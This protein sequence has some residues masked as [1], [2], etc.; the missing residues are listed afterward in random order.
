MARFTS[1]RLLLAASLAIL[2]AVFIGYL[3][4]VRKHCAPYATNTDAAGYVHSARLLTEGRLAFT[5]PALGSIAPPDWQSTW[6]QPFGFVADASGRMVPTY[7]VGY[8]LHLAV[9]AW[10][11]GIDWAVVLANVAISGA[12]AL[13]MAALCREFH[14][15]WVWCC[16]GAALLWASPVVVY[17]ELWAMSDVASTAWCIASVLGALRA[18]RQ[19]CWSIAAGLAAGIAVLVRPTN[20]LLLPA[21]AAAVG[22]R[23]RNWL[24]VIGGAAP[25]AAF[26]AWYNLALYGSAFA[27]GYSGNRWAFQGKFVL[28]TLGHFALGLPLLL[29]PVVILAGL[30]V[31]RRTWEIPRTRLVLS[32]WILPF[33]GFYSCYYFSS[34]SWWFVRFLMPVFPALILGAL[35]TA[36]HWCR[37]SAPTH[38]LRRIVVVTAFATALLWDVVAVHRMHAVNMKRSE[39]VYVQAA[40]WLRDHAPADSLVVAR[41]ASGTLAFYTSLP[42]IRYDLAG[43]DAMH[44]L[45][46]TA[47]ASS[48][49]VF[50]VLCDPEKDEAFDHF[51]PGRWDLRSRH[52]FFGVWQ[53][54]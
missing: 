10:F 26:L 18:R 21:L 36:E 33:V 13:L 50:V 1:S 41:Q 12:T 20:V 15:P 49:P 14:L 32:A 11:V 31:W 23:W 51:L 6:Q 34:L 48:R 46:A 7:P 3:W 19:W 25:P 53:R 44:R 40:E 5:A 22:L 43:P 28:P 47:H 37:D 2:L 45:L 35:L 30:G 39:I 4:F 54:L 24:G 8:P 9:A 29:S 42:I 38:R 16:A 27:T 17:L 52:G